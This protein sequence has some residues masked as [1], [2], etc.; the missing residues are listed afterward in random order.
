L[1]VRTANR[2]RWMHF[3]EI[4]VVPVLTTRATVELMMF[5]TDAIAELRLANDTPAFFIDAVA[6]EQHDWID[7]LA[8]RIVWPA[9]KR[10]PFAFSIPA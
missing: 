4:A 9:V 8:E 5:A 7:G 1:S 3:P 2:D 6:G 10:L